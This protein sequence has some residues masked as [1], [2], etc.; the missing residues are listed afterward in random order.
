ME[1]NI[2]EYYTQQYQLGNSPIFGID[3]GTVFNNSN[4]DWLDVFYHAQYSFYRLDKPCIIF[5]PAGT[6]TFSRTIQIFTNAKLRGDGKNNTTIRFDWSL[7]AILPNIAE[8]GGNTPYYKWLDGIVFHSGGAGAAGANSYS[9]SSLPAPYLMAVPLPTNLSFSNNEYITFSQ[10]KSSGTGLTI[11]KL[12]LEFHSAGNV[13]IPEYPST[14]LEI[15]AQSLGINIPDGLAEIPIKYPYYGHGINAHG[16]VSLHHCAIKGFLGD[17]IH[18]SSTTMGTSAFLEQYLPLF[19]E[20]GLPI[21]A[22]SAVGDM[23]LQVQGGTLTPTNVL[24]LPTGIPI[25][26]SNA[27]GCISTYT[28]ISNCSGHGIFTLGG[29][30]NT[31]QFIGM[32]ISNC[33]G[34]GILEAGSLGNIYIGCN[35]YGCT[36]GSIKAI[37]PL[38]AGYYRYIDNSAS[39]INCHTDGEVILI[40]GQGKQQWFGGIAHLE[41]GQNPLGS[42][43]YTLPHGIQMSKKNGLRFFNAQK[44]DA[45]PNNVIPSG[46]ISIGFAQI[47]PNRLLDFGEEWV[48]AHRPDASFKVIQ[49]SAAASYNHA[50]SLSNYHA[51]IPKG[52]VWFPQRFYLSKPSPNEEQTYSHNCV[53]TNAG[54]PDGWYYGTKDFP[55]QEGSAI[56]RFA[57]IGDIVF[58]NDPIPGE[59]ATN[60]PKR[61][62]IAYMC[63]RG[64]IPKLDIQG[65]ISFIDEVGNITDYPQMEILSEWKCFGKL[66]TILLLFLLAQ[67]IYA[68]GWT[69]VYGDQLNAEVGYDM[70]LNPNNEIIM[71][72]AVWHYEG[73]TMQVGNSFWVF[74]TI[75]DTLYTKF[76]GATNNVISTS[77]SNYLLL[78]SYNFNNTTNGTTK[79][80]IKID[81]ESDTIWSVLSP[82]VSDVVQLSDS[83]FLSIGSVTASDTYF[84]GGTDVPCNYEVQTPTSSWI[85]KNGNLLSS[86]IWFN[87]NDI[88][89]SICNYLQTTTNSIID[90]GNNHFIIAGYTHNPNNTYERMNFIA[91]IQGTDLSNIVWKDKSVPGGAYQ[92]IRANDGTYLTIGYKS[93]IQNQGFQ[94]SRITKYSANGLVLWTKILSDTLKLS[95]EIINLSNGNHLGIM[96]YNQPYLTMFDENWDTIWQKAYHFENPTYLHGILAAPN[97]GYYLSG[98]HLTNTDNNVA[99]LILIKIDS[100]G[101][102]RPQA[103]F[104]WEQTDSLVSVSNHSFGADAYTW[105]WGNGQS[106]LDSTDLAQQ[107]IYPQTGSYNLCLVAHNLCGNDTLCQTINYFP[108]GMSH[109]TSNPL[110]VFPNPTSEQLYVTFPALLSPAVWCLYDSA[111]QVVFSQNLPAG[112]M[113]VRYHTTALPLGVYVLELQTADWSA[114]QK[115]VVM[116]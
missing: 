19:D 49:S 85:D 22:T 110:Q 7:D 87:Y 64:G 80:I 48:L 23:P 45:T 36:S 33:E 56:C 38:A 14:T 5:F 24:N 26:G 93:A 52:N 1:I 16:V 41:P 63:V 107:Y 104:T 12:C 70:Q 75:G 51:D 68:Q 40:H 112:T 77:D 101:S 72:S 20:H 21:P 100:T 99:D 4:F 9:T 79:S 59:I 54:I 95:K 13:N 108:I 94:G 69:K 105:L 32:M 83:S 34:W 96:N 10:V 8:Y 37:A 6:Y 97:G 39:F 27:C 65:N 102:C 42:S 67:T 44:A 89:G 82:A 11:E 17:G 84:W 31:C 74:N 61:G 114:Q 111:G 2:R 35:I 113:Q 60:T 55:L 88:Q 106:L 91:A 78:G 50:L 18:I 109:P 58:N 57:K 53:T 43:G 81:S 46:R 98:A 62:Y 30:A 15:I 86:S 76:R 66:L 71:R 3:P 28:N 47:E 29:D 25:P 90:M 116:R 92:L 115:V 103:A 73:N